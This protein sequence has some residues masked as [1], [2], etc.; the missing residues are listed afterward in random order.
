MN[1]RK[2]FAI[3]LA[4]LVVLSFAACDGGGGGSSSDNGGTNNGGGNGGGGGNNEPEVTWP[5]RYTTP[6]LEG[7]EES[8]WYLYIDFYQDGKLSVGQG[9]TFEGVLQEV[10][11]GDGT[12]TGD[13][14]HGDGTISIKGT[15]GEA[16][17]DGDYIMTRGL[18]AGLFGVNWER[19]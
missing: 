12:W 4:L 2:V 18:L 1:L 14:P 3:L 19:Q 7:G 13:D 9:G 6:N 5:V 10:P 16:L 15:F 8:D 11:A 17:V